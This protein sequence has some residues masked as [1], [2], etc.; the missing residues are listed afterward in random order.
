MLALQHFR[1]RHQVL[2]PPVRAGTE[3]NLVNGHGL[4][5]LHRRDMV[6]I[7]RQRHDG[8]KVLRTVPKY[9]LAGRIRIARKGTLRFR[10]FDSEIFRSL[11]IRGKERTL[12]PRL[13]S[14]ICHGHAG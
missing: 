4:K 14:H 8:H 6:H 12:C 3:E 10:E 13:N 9:P 5:L 7:R 11:L 2:K 1:S